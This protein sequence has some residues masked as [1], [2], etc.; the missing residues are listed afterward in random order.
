MGNFKGFFCHTDGGLED[1]LFNVES[2]LTNLGFGRMNYGGLT[3][4][5]TVLAQL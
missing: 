3:V 2:R 4:K 5:T 1:V